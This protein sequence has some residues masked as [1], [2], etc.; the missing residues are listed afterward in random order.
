T[1]QMA[2]RLIAANASV[3]GVD[4]S[5]DIVGT[6]VVNGTQ[7]Q[8]FLLSHG[9]VTPTPLAPPGSV[10]SEAL[11]L[12]NTGQV[13]GEYTDLQGQT[14]AFLYDIN[15]KTD[16]APIAGTIPNTIA[17][18]ISDNASVLVGTYTDAHGSHGLVGTTVPA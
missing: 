4:N 10:S 2:F 11:G 14:H 13:V 15:T 18:G 9:S 8:A 1:G 12:N 17:T 16:Q 3:D 7:R 6:E 5:G